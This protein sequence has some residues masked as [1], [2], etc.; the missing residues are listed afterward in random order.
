MTRDAW[1][2]E[3][4]DTVV[5]DYFSMLAD[6]L[7]GRQYVKAS[8][9]RRLQ[10]LIN[11]SRGSIDYKYQNISAVLQAAG[12]AWISGYKPAFNYQMSLEDAVKRWLSRNPDWLQRLPA[13]YAG[14]AAG[15]MIREE[16]ACLAL[17]YEAAPDQSHDLP[18]EIMAQVD[19]IARKFDV[20]A[21]DERNRRLG[22]AGEEHVLRLERTLLRQ[23]G[24][25]DLARKVRWVSREDGDGAGYD[26][27]SFDQYGTSRL[28]E[29]KTTNGWART[30]F[31][32]SCNELNVAEAC[33][34]EWKLVR[35]W[36]FSRAPRAFEM[37][38]PLD[39]NVV[40][41]PTNFRA[42]FR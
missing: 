31:H 13:W 28:I 8:H 15:L 27:A 23:A 2:D 41:S 11:R 16:P 12:E 14:A 32:I 24:R 6:D 21:R 20:A 17:Q 26:I 10:P 9:N 18:K 19:A 7:A 5:A 3:E 1:S 42:S 25:D 35:V 30:P 40:L 36:N 38:P 22:I 4:N 29:V 37:H 34:S 39:A 33:R